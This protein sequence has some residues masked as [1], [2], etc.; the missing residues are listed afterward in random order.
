[1]QEYI[2]EVEA[3]N[4]N[5]KGFLKDFSGVLGDFA[6]KN[7][8]SIQSWQDRFCEMAGVYAFCL[9]SNEVPVSSFSG[10]PRE[11]K[12]IQKYVTDV[13]IHNIF[14]RVSE[15]ELEDQ[16][17]EITEVPNLKLAA[18]AVKNDNSTAAVWI[19][20]GVFTDEEYEKEFYHV[21]PL[22]S[23]AYQISEPKFYKTL[24]FLR[25]SMSVVLGIETS[26]TMAEASSKVSKKQELEMTSS[27]RRAETMTEIVSLLD[28]DDSIEEIMVDMLSKLCDYLQVS[29][30]YIC[31]V[32]HGHLMDIVVQWTAAGV[33]KMFP[34]T[35]DQ[36][37]CWFLGTD[38][39]VVVSS[40][41]QMNA[42]EREQLDNLSIKALVTMPIIVNG[43]VLFYACFTETR[44]IRIWSIDDIKYINDAIRVLQS[45]ITKRLQKNSL[46]SSF[47]SLESVLDN[48]GS[49]IYVRDIETGVLL[50]AN[51]SFKKNFSKEIS[52]NS[53]VDL[54][55]S[56]I[57]S[58]SRSGNYEV[59][60]RAR[61]KWYDVYYTRIKWVDGRP[62]SL[63][64]L[65]DITE[66]KLYQRRIELQAYTDFL[67]GLYNR[68][69]CE[70][71]LA[72]YVD[73]ARQNDTHGALMYLDL[74]DFKHINDSLGHQYGDILLQDISKS[75]SRIEGIGNSCY[76][77]GGDEFVI[78]VPPDSYGRLDKIL[79]EI[80]D[81]FATPW[82]LKDSDYYC[83]MS[84]G[85]VKFPDHGDSVSEL[86]RKSDVAMYEAKKSGKNRVAEYS[87]N[88]DSSSIHRLDLE[89]SMYDAIGRS[90]EE[91][92]VF[93]QPIIS[94]PADLKSGNGQFKH[95]GAEALVRWNSG[96][97]GFLSPDEFVPLAEYLGLINP[98]GNYVLKKAC[99][100]CRQ[101]NESGTGEFTI[102]VNLSVVQIM[103]TD[104]VDIIKECIEE[105]HLKPQ[106]LILELTERLA[107]NDLART[108]QTLLDI[109]A[110]GVR[111][112]LDDFGTG[113]SAL[114]S[115][116]ALPFDIIKVDQNFS[117]GIETDDYSKAFIKTISQLGK[118]IGAE[119][120][121]EGIETKQQLGALKGLG[122]K[123]VQGYYYDK[124]LR[125]A[126]FE[127]KYVYS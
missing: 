97:L 115:L 125:R 74:D 29:N 55:E 38:K 83:T 4:A 54:F 59:N 30:S 45:I 40:D 23:F 121:V 80:K 98:I 25:E 88:I 127:E 48:V 60:H 126:A 73:E 78:I 79:E 109:K 43:T 90:C 34:N 68:M 12:I 28:S 27:F 94:Q 26:R 64:A 44:E 32:H 104:I 56:N 52:E 42:G 84:M 33:S 72:R 51:R 112:A 93:F 96:K 102:S 15:S 5:V 111:L 67:T 106:N 53:L 61:G 87:D 62:V 36:E 8:A 11:I 47:A 116:R 120:C 17:V 58:R 37:K 81:A 3:K 103:Q 19:V 108:K 18:V 20:C 75:I 10:N 6:Q 65:Y 105:N 14:K 110:L 63:C 95:I 46:A 70:K 49:S 2:K 123:Y 22:E 82:Y 16:A 21:P 86:I 114:S 89:K 39:A 13:R 69:C 1:M 71:D 119:V 99:E 41:S 117:K 113:Y 85:I 100:C 122:V 101:W 92:E 7:A 124:P 107:I 24:D 57:P 76:R 118:T 31:R 9:D 35:T 91:F 66:K 50:F 77:M